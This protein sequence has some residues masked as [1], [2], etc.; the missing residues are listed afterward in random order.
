MI[1]IVRLLPVA[2]P[3]ALLGGCLSFGA[4]PPKTLMVLTTSSPIEPNA[5]RTATADNTVLV[6]T[7]TAPVAIG[8]TR[9]PVYDGSTNLAYVVDAGWNEPP[10]RAMQRII[11]DTITARTSKIVLDPRQFATSPA[12]RLSGQLQ[13]FGVEPGALQVVV[14]FDAQLSRGSDRVE[15]RR[16]EA[17]APITAIIG[18]EVGAAL[19]VAA[20]D[21][22]TQIA[23][24]VG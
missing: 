21:L 15:T 17:R 8:T 19:N 9:I 10:A 5:V 16:F 11:S 13:R 6:L 18:P 14:V 22:A 7:P 3:V 2:L 1:R 4:K 23:G 20:N 12:M 24:W